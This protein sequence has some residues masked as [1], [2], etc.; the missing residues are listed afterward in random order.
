[1]GYSMRTPEYR[2]TR[3]VNRETR[4]T[5]DIEIYDHRGMD[6]EMNNLAA[7]VEYQE[8]TDKLDK[9]LDKHYS[10][11]HTMEFLEFKE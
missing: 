6:L 4:E 9:E 3:W 11:E 2:I 7:R 8:L 1:M 5:L 10:I